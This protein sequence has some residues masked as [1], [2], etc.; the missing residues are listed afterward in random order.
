MPEKQLPQEHKSLLEQLEA[1]ALTAIASEIPE[2]IH[3]AIEFI[4][5]LVHAKKSPPPVQPAA[6]GPGGTPPDPGPT[7]PPPKG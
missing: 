5:S 4:K 1:A 3:A 7:P 6:D 2:A